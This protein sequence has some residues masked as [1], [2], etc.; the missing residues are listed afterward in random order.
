MRA[1]GPLTPTSRTLVSAWSL[2]RAPSPP[3]LTGDSREQIAETREEIKEKRGEKHCIKD[4]QFDSI[5]FCSDL[6][7]LAGVVAVEEMGGPKVLSFDM[8]IAS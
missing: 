7:I 1:S 6:W 5:I 2:S 4:T 3:S 8:I